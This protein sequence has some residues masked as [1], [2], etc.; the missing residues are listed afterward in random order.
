MN[1]LWI[2]PTFRTGYKAKRSAPPAIFGRVREGILQLRCHPIPGSLG[3]RKKGGLSETHAWTIN[4]ENRILYGVREVEG[5]TVVALLRVCDHRAAYQEPE[6][7]PAERAFF[8]QVGSVVLGQTTE[9][10]SWLAS[11]E[12]PTPPRR[13]RTAYQSE[14]YR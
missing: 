3:P 13:S 4:L 6:L 5:V 2:T 12:E 11:R 14:M 10:E 1:R 7:S 8:S 9:S